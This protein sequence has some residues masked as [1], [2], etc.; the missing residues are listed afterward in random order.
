MGLFTLFLIWVVQY[1]NMKKIEALENPV[2]GVLQ[3]EDVLV[4]PK[5]VYD[6]PPTTNPFS[7][8]LLTDYAS[9]PLKKPAPSMDDPKTQDA[10]LSSAKELVAD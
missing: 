1:S 10:I 6:D 9:N 5:E 4:D 7:N 8:V 3:D 2:D